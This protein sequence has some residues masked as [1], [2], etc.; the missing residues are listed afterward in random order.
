MIGV[1]D[2]GTT[3]EEE[4]ES[5]NGREEEEEFD[6]ED[7]MGSDGEVKGFVWVDDLLI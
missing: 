6:E 7:E 3:I 4:K 5:R 1:M 2:N